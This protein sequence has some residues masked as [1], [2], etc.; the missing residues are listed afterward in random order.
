MCGATQAQGLIVLITYGLSPRVRGHPVGKGTAFRILGS[1]PACAGPPGRAYSAAG[2]RKVYPRVCGATL[3]DN[4]EDLNRN[5]LSPRVRGHLPATRTGVAYS[6]SIPACA[7]PPHLAGREWGACRVYPRVCGA[8]VPSGKVTDG[9]S[10]LSPRV[11]GHRGAV[12][13]GAFASGSIPACAG[14][15][16]RRPVEEGSRR[17]YPRVCGATDHCAEKI[18]NGVGL[19]PRVRGHP[20][21]ASTGTCRARSIPACA[22]PPAPGGQAMWRTGVYPRV[23][24]ATLAE[25]VPDAFVKG[26]SPRVRGHPCYSLSGTGRYGPFAPCIAPKSDSLSQGATTSVRNGQ[27]G[28]ECKRRLG[29][30]STPRALAAAPATCRSS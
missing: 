23:C 4:S 15:P 11:R 6:R 12:A 5:G 22:G 14:P 27:C 30:R 13:R 28:L 21:A 19:S 3:I 29:D 20:V 9:S 25:N 10:G 1:I 26:L 16:R 18:Q 8:T 7:G 24:G 17:V 2:R